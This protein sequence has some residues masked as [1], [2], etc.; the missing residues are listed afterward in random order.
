MR[1]SVVVDVK[2]EMCLIITT[3]TAFASASGDAAAVT[4]VAALHNRICV[5]FHSLR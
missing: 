4:A 1:S 2:R 5:P 3:A